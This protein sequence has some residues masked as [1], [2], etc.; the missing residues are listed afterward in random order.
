MALNRR[1][2]LLAALPGFAGSLA[3]P[4]LGHAQAPLKLDVPFAPT[5]FTL[6]DTMLRIANV[7]AKDYV[8]DLGSGD[9]RI[10][11]AAARDW[12]AAGIGYE[13]DPALVADSIALAKVA[14]VSD[15]VQFTEQNLFDS[16]ISKAT[17]VTLYLGVKV[18]LRV[19]P[20]LLAELRPG[21]RVVSHDFDLGEWK[22]DLHIRLREYGSNVFF[23]WVPAR[24]AGTWV[25]R[26]ETPDAGVRT[27]EVVLRQ[28]FQA[29]DAEVRAEGARVGLRDIRLAGD[30]LTFIMMEEVKKQFTFRR[31]FG[32]IARD[33]NTI[34]GYFRTETEGMRNET[35]FRMT[36]TAVADP[37]PPGAWTY[38]R[39]S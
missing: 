2:A 18:N 34:D 26:A 13:L 33:G 16:D 36:R 8:I 28:Q 29:L 6:I 23:W 1:R 22:P 10:N 14:R 32:R 17:V 11:I 19:R 27:Y 31:F 39:G 21:T 24:V 3:L 4:M 20:K 35:P 12:G 7:T 9:G 30:G 15:R 25:T 37:G 38:V 5:N